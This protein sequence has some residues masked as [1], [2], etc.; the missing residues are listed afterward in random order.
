[1]AIHGFY[2]PPAPDGLFAAGGSAGVPLRLHAVDGEWRLDLDGSRRS[3]GS[4]H[5]ALEAVSSLRPFLDDFIGKGGFD[6]VLA[7]RSGFALLLTTGMGRGYA[8]L[9]WTHPSTGRQISMAGQW[10]PADEA[11]LGAAAFAPLAPFFSKQI[12]DIPF[13]GDLWIERSSDVTVSTR[14][15]EHAGELLAIRE[16]FHHVFS[17]H[18]LPGSLRRKYYVLPFGAVSNPSPPASW[19]D[20]IEVEP[21]EVPDAVRRLGG[22]VP[23]KSNARVVR[24]SGAPG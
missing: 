19:E 9:I 18:A 11:G 22:L 17:R 15:P 5:E 1:M 3:E 7:E 23:S 20:W 8:S 4:A 24:S 16:V 13:S 21:I 10:I 14:S 12:L 6:P 2:D